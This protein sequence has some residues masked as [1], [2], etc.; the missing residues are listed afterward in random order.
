VEQDYMYK[1]VC[2]S[3]TYHWT[4]NVLTAAYVMLG[5]TKVHHQQRYY[6][7]AGDGKNSLLIY[8]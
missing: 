5:G 3:A 7:R 2:L 6:S 1:F 8:I 4:R